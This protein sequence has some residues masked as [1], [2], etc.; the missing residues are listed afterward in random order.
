[1]PSKW[2]EARCWQ[3]HEPQHTAWA[4]ALVHGCCGPLAWPENA[5]HHGWMPPDA[6]RRPPGQ[7]HEP[8]RAPSEFH[9]HGDD[10][11]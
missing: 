3:E 11:M 1:M 2:H 4:P 5:A 7:C 9:S 6:T 8:W 10:C